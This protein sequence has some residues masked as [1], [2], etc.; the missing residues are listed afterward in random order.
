LLYAFKIYLAMALTD[1]KCKQ[2]DNIP[3][4]EIEL[5]IAE[6]QREIDKYQKELDALI[7]DR[8]GNKLAIYMREGKISQREE[9]VSNLNSILKYRKALA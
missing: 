1:E 2:N 4:S 5:D 8:Q 7:G 3:T 6:T 9:F